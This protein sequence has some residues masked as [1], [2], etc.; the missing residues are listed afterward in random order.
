MGRLIQKR[1]LPE[2]P[3]S[4]T[5]GDRAIYNAMMTQM[6][7]SQLTNDVKPGLMK[8]A[9]KMAEAIVGD[10]IQSDPAI[11][12]RKYLHALS[13]VAGLAPGVIRLHPE[14]ESHTTVSEAAANAGFSIELDDT[15]HPGDCIIETADVK[16]D[17]TVSTA[18]YHFKKCLH[19]AP[20]KE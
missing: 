17:A 19:G 13:Q 4:L 20:L 16:V 18:L 3:L 9:L 10:T 11:L 8:V 14:G 12:E 7:R 6:T 15:L 1:H 2:T 5:Q